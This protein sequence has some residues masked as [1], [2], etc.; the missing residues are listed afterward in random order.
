MSSHISTPS[1]LNRSFTALFDGKLLKPAQLT[2]LRTTVKVPP[3]AGW[4]AG[5]VRAG[6]GQHAAQLWRPDVGP[7]R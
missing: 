1:D 5:P 7:R 3:A 2:Q 6:C 4:W